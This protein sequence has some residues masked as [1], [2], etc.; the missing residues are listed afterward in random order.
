MK[1]SKLV[2]VILLS[3]VSIFLTYQIFQTSSP[4]FFRS[5]PP[6]TV[7]S[8]TTSPSRINNI[9]PTIKSLTQ[10]Q[11]VKADAAYLNLPERFGRTGESYTIP[12]FL[13]NY[14][15][16]I[17]RCEVDYGPITKLVPTL[18]KEKDP[19]TRIIILDDDIEYD[20]ELVERFHKY[21]S[22][23]P[24]AVLSNM[25]DKW[26]WV[27]S[28]IPDPYCELVE[29]WGGIF[30]RRDMF[31][32]DFMDYVNRIVMSGKS[33]FGGDDLVISNYLAKH[34][35][36]R[37]RLNKQP[38]IL[39]LGLGADA[40]HVIDTNESDR[41]DKCKKYIAEKDGKYSLPN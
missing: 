13:N 26:N 24:N 33:C 30:F 2:I 17:N 38:T 41:Y 10:S 6:R 3:V 32:S 25:C 19:N 37:V 14:S 22:I 36:P 23:Y 15:I 20:S 9:E 1:Y 16:T 34:N 7:I 29:G 35:V 28:D 8:F 39:Q 27:K 12:D 21:T 40:L 4:E 11:T 5:P 18:E 31:K